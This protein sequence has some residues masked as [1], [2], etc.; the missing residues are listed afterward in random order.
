MN[1]RTASPFSAASAAVLALALISCGS[2]NDPGGG[3]DPSGDP[4]AETVDPGSTTGTPGS[5][6]TTPDPDKPGC[7]QAQYTEALPTT[8]SLSGLSFSSAS[9]DTYLLA[10]LDKR[11]PLGKAIVEGGLSSPL[12]QSQGSCI[13]RF[14]QDTSS[15]AAVL[16]QAPTVVHECGHFY[17]LGE[18]G[19]TSH[20]YVIRTDLTFTCKAGDTT[21]RGGKTFARSLIKT[22]AYYPKREACGATLTKGCD[23]YAGYYLSGDPTD[24]SFQAGD[25]GYNSLLEEASQYVNSLA[26]GLAFVSENQTAGGSHRDGMLT[27]L[28]YLERYLKMAREDY[29]T[30]YALLSEDACWRQATLTVWD[31]GWF[32][33]DATS[34]MTKLGYDDAALMTLVKDPTLTSEIDALRQLECQ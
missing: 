18:A 33:L 1:R 2:A 28:W 27:F 20:A 9:A 3:N 8:S 10:A 13:D 15:A 34:G 16:R 30:A 5:G 12:A 29:P 23:F 31:R 26:T 6:G 24:G 21:S 22:D 7:A 11:F 32:Y 14:L 25:Q 17:D 19:G 4:N